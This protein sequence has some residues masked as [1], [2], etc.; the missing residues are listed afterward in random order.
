M[1]LD[2]KTAIVYG[3]A[4]SIGSA[5]ARGFATEGAS[6]HLVGRTEE[7]V[8]RVTD[9][10]VA[11]GGRAEYAVFDVM[12]SAAVDRHADDVVAATG[13]LDISFTAISDNDVQGTAMAEM[14]VDDYLAPVI[15]NVRSKFNTARAAAR[16]MKPQGGGVLLYFGGAPNRAPFTDYYIGGV[17][18]AFEAVEAM[19]RQLSSELGRHGIRVV[20]L[21]T[22]GIAESLPADFEGRDAIVEAFANDSLLGRG[23]TLADV[24]G[25]AAFVASDRAGSMTAATVN[26]SC[27]ALVD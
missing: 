26:V 22:G 15:T 23:A 7:P 13:R 8:R 21:R 25:V 14:D 2:G 19:R 17:L 5:V 18:A 9:E 27:G 3:G 6:V 1:L 20:T 16:H 24:A 12:D 4:G 11:A 10:I